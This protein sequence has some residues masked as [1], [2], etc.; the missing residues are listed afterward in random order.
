MEPGDSTPETPRVKA[1]R[2]RF[3]W[4]V[5]TITVLA[6]ATLALLPCYCNYTVRSQV[7]EG[8]SLAE[9]A[10]TAVSDYYGLHHA[11]PVDNREA[12]LTGP[13][14]IQGSYVTSIIIASG[15]VVA[16]YGNQADSAIAGKSLVFR[17]R[18]AGGSLQWD[19]TTAAGTTVPVRE[20]PTACRP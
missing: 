2:R 13:L 16:S 10:K 5:L 15:T 17:P 20:R 14:S 18:P 1:R 3:L 8:S 4:P 19:C 9:G 11:M 12:G 7:S 6:L